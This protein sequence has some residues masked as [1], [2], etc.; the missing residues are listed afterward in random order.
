VYVDETSVESNDTDTM[1]RFSND[2]GRTWSAPIRVN[3]DT[4]QNSQFLPR[5]AIDD[6]SGNIAVCWHDCRNSTD[7][8]AVQVFCTSATP[9]D[10]TP[11]FLPSV[12]ISD[13]SSVSYGYGYEFGDY[14][15][16]EYLNGVAYPIW[17]STSDK[18]LDNPDGGKGYDVLTDRLAGG[19][20]KI[21]PSKKKPKKPRPAGRR[22][23][24]PP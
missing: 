14:W 3:D 20:K 4:S 11:Q 22:R 16:L 5:I 17:A 8:R 12:A 15:G 2:D 23:P 10:E 19:T 18:I 21:G 6:S 24:K 1:L 13:G 7:N 9:A